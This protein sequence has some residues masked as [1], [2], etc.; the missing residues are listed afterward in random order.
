MASYTSN[1]SFMSSIKNMKRT[2]AIQRG[3]KFTCTMEKFLL[4]KKNL[5]I[6]NNSR[7][8]VPISRGLPYLVVILPTIRRETVL[9]QLDIIKYTTDAPGR[10]D[11][12]GICFSLF[13]R[14]QDTYVLICRH[15]FHSDCIREWMAI[16]SSCP[17]CRC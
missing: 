6:M 17:L 7:E 1:M 11:T 15:N 16:K 3:A 5:Q 10:N 8:I 2:L 9:D 4:K 12:C 13:E 14:D